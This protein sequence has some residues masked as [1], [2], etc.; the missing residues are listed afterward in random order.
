MRI[1]SGEDLAVA[2]AILADLRMELGL[3]TLITP[4]KSKRQV[5]NGLLHRIRLAEADIE[6]SRRYG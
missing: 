5:I 6:R 4:T 2:E 3:A 1:Y